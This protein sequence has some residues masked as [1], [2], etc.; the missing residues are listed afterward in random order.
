MFRAG[1][2]ECERL[3]IRRAA[4]VPA[5]SGGRSSPGCTHK[6]LPCTQA[7]FIVSNSFVLSL[8]TGARHRARVLPLFSRC[9]GSDVVAATRPV[10]HIRGTAGKARR[11]VALLQSSSFFRGPH[12]AQPGAECGDGAHKVGTKQEKS[13]LGIVPWGEGAPSGWVRLAPRASPLGGK[14]QKD[15]C[16]MFHS[17][18]TH[19]TALGIP[20]CAGPG[21]KPRRRC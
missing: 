19:W 14:A 10:N 6:S 7:A 9:G 3:F 20:L 13:P 4:T 8:G 17:F 21:A 1:H 11:G 12:K 18:F 16:D 2:P 5:G 15:L